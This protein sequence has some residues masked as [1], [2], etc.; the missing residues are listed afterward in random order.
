MLGLFL[1]LSGCVVIS[2]YPLYT[3]RDLSPNK[4]LLGSWVDKDS[5]VWAFDYKQ[6]NNQPDSCTYLLQIKEKEKSD[7]SNVKLQVHVVCLDDTYWLDFYLD[8]YSPADNL[9]FFDFH[10]LP[11]HT[12]A[13]L[14]F[15]DGVAHI[16]W[17]SKDWLEKLVK[18]GKMKFKY[19]QNDDYILLTDKP[20]EL[21]NF[22]RK[23]AD[24]DTAFVDGMDVYLSKTE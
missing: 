18:S 1:V 19:E 22:L 12:F 7:F 6:V 21:Q 15:S 20:H 23:W 3:T 13:R 16:Q 14:S 24:S 2:F 17:L 5:S 9:T 4:M 8:E 11:V 10:L